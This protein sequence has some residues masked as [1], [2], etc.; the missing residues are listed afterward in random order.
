MTFRDT[1]GT[2]DQEG[3]RKFIFPKKPSGKF[4]D[5]RKWVSY[6]NC[7]I[8]NPFFELIAKQ[9]ML[10]N[11]LERRFN[12]F[13]FPFGHKIL[14]FRFIYDRRSGLCDLFTVIFV[15]FVDGFVPNYISRNGFLEELNIDREEI[16]VTRLSKQ[17]WN[18]EKIRKKD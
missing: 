10:F 7:L 13:G 1:I 5:Y 16:V 17:E 4:Y 3:K 8:A 6:T 14:H 11:I 18:A 2:I 12:I 15:F 9:F